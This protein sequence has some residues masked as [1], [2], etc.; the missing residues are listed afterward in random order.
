MKNRIKL[1]LKNTFKGWAVYD[2]KEDKRKSI[3]Y[4]NRED[5]KTHMTFLLSR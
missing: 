3:F 1:T 5:A 2:K 4:K